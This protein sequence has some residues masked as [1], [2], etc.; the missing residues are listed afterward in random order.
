MAMGEQIAC[1]HMSF[2]SSFL[3]HLAHGGLFFLMHVGSE[4]A[5]FY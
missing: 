5:C 2:G 4:N 3:A 1:E